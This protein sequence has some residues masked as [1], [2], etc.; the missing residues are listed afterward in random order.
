MANLPDQNV[1]KKSYNVGAPRTI[2]CGRRELGASDWGLANW[3]GD[4]GLAHRELGV[5]VA[6]TSHNIQDTTDNIGSTTDNLER[7]TDY[8]EGITDKPIERD[9]MAR[10]AA[11]QQIIDEI[12][13]DVERRSLG[14]SQ[15][16]MRDTTVVDTP[17]AYTAD[18]M[19][20]SQNSL[21]VS[22]RNASGGHQGPG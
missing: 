4:I 17:G 11:A 3:R 21:T 14:L 1:S 10:S 5:S 20:G 7:T 9:T 8:P 2:G 6:E 13:R 18:G 22:A 16:A 12:F 19:Q 15:D